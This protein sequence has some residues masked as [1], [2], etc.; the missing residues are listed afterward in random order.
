MLFR[1]VKLLENTMFGQRLEKL[2][3]NRYGFLIEIFNVETPIKISD[4]FFVA[5]ACQAHNCAS[6]AVSIVY[7]FSDNIMYAAIMEEGE[8]KIYWDKGG[9]IEKIRNYTTMVYW[10]N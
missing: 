10:G 9:D 6:T 3:G 1:S 5:E 8:I 7:D 4:N 2:V